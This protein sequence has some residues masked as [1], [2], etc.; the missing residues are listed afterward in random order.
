MNMTTRSFSPRFFPVVILF[1]VVVFSVML[2][3]PATVSANHN[4]AKDVTGYVTDIMG[5]PLPGAA[6]S[7]SID[8]FTHSTTTD[9][10][11]FYQAPQFKNSDWT[12]GSTI[13]V[14]VTYN[15]QP[16]ASTA[17]ADGNPTQQ[18]NVQYPYE[19][20]Q[21]GGSLGL[22]LAGGFVAAISIVL[23]TDKKRK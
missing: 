19:I 6:V 18:V 11:G 1:A 9:S 14:N 23:L 8:G 10:N 3:V 17:V 21:L 5:N 7:V 16:A 2:M 20:P 4:H 22:L 13:Y 12:M 15:S